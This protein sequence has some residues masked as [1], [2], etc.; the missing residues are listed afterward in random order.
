LL[1]WE[2]NID[3]LDTTWA[4][5]LLRDDV[6]NKEKLLRQKTEQKLKQKLTD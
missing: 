5:F 1:Y 6:P 2:K 4:P 3:T